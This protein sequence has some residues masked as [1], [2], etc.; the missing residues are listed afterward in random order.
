[1]AINCSRHLHG[2]NFKPKIEYFG[3]AVQI[4]GIRFE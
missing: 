4:G 1:M 3:E 2:H